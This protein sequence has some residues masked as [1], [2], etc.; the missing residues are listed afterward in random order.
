M[1]PD[2]DHTRPPRREVDDT[3][4]DRP[5]ASVQNG[6]AGM[7]VASLLL[8]MMSLCTGPITGIPA[9][10]CS[11]SALKK[12]VGQGAAITGLILGIL[13]SMI[14]SVALITFLLPAILKVGDT[15]NQAREMNNL[16]QIGIAMHNHH[17]VKNEFPP[18]TGDLSWRVHILPYIEQNNLHRRFDQTQPWDSPKNR[19]FSDAVVKTYQSP[20]DSPESIQTHYRVFVGP[21]TIYEP[22]KRPKRLPEITDGTSNTLLAVEAAETVPWAQPKELAFSAD[23]DLP[24]LGH[25]DRDVVL[26]LMADGS[27]RTVSKTRLDPSLLRAIITPNG[28]EAVPKDW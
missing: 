25:P 16:K 5:G 3:Q 13:G 23:G 19:S 17:D 27:I 10:I 8:G 21:G 15:A 4:D 14:V 12:P 1:S 22:G 6:S 9:I 2:D 24:A 7:A 18:A 11:V 20:L 28:G 26:I